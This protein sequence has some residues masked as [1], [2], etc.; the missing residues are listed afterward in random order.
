MPTECS[1]DRCGFGVVSGRD[2]VASFA[3]EAMTSDVGAL[4]PDA[5]DRAEV[6]KV[7]SA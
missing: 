6:A 7:P 3:G 1:A 2:V 4:L 5:A